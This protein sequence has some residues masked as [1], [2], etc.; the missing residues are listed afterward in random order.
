M[1]IVRLSK[2][3]LYGTLPDREAVLAGLQQLGCLH[4]LD[5]TTTAGDVAAAKK[6]GQTERNDVAEA[7]RYLATSPSTN[8]RQRAHYD[9]DQTALSVAREILGLQRRT[10]QLSDRVDQL[11]QQIETLQPWG[12]FQP[13]PPEQLG[14]QRL[15]FYRVPL[16]VLGSLQQ[17]PHVWQRIA[18]DAESAS[19]VVIAAD[20]P[21]WPWED[22]ELPTQPLSQLR[23][24]WEA[25]QNDLE[26]CHWQRVEQT[27]WLTLL[28]RDLAATDDRLERLVAAHQTMAQEPVFALQ[29]WAPENALT[30]LQNFAAERRLALTVSD[31]AADEQPPTLLQNPRAVAGAEDAVTF[32]MTPAYRAWDPTWIMFISFTVFFAMIV[33]DAAYGLIYGLGLG[34]VWRKLSGDETLRRLRN[35]FLALV[36]ATIGWGVLAGSYFGTTPS[37]LSAV[38]LQVEGQP[39]LTHKD[40]MMMLSLG[41]GVFHLVLANVITAWQQ[42]G[43]AV[44]LSAVGWAAGIA[45]GY[46]LG[47]FY[48]ANYKASQWL[49]ESAGWAAESFQ[50]AL[51]QL[52][53]SGLIGGLGLV[54]LFSS[55]RPLWSRR[56]SDWGWRL[57]DGLLGLTN[58][59]K[60]FGDTLSYLRLFALG[61]ASAQLAVTFNNIA[62]DLYGMPGIGM[63]LGFFVLL[64][65][66][67]VNLLLGIMGGVVHGLRLNCIEFFNWSLTEEGQPFRAFRKKA[68]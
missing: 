13:I 11:Q 38:Q 9:P 49:A 63:V 45:G 52:G 62:S 55:R 44:A 15:W 3:T 21:E 20:P 66:H 27:H 58:V 59:T 51:K 39:L 33:S 50:P 56:P 34:L 18:Q 17:Q 22:L 16:H 28:Q 36:L 7:I 30:A 43:Q 67:G 1:S 41:I 6:R 14:G 12:E 54:L 26:S 23:Q 2:V 4:L 29:A 47:L 48:E 64:L 19:V 61:F 65:G 37:G 68:T 10:E 24:A 53:W 32:Y 60:A 46:L 35:L 40:A 31:P 5:L 57:I 8:P 25:T 42:R